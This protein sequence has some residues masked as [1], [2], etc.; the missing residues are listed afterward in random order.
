MKILALDTSSEY[1]SM[2][3][4]EDEKLLASQHIA[5]GRQLSSNLIKSVDSILKTAGWKLLDVDCFC[6]GLGPGS[7]TGLRIGITCMKGFALAL[8]K[9][10]KGISSLDVI[11]YEGRY[12]SG[13]ICPIIDAKKNMVYTAVYEAKDGSIVR[14]GSYNVLKIEGLLKKLKGE[15]LFLG[16]A[17][18]IYKDALQRNGLKPVFASQK[19]WYP[20]ADILTGL[21]MKDIL[22]RKFDDVHKLNPLY[23]HPKECTVTK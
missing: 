13:T 12:F 16:D 6:V 7:F 19:L 9:P 2:A 11:A 8:K 18:S 14:K 1:M 5:F 3:L 4:T 20:R 15:V 17:I 21:C 10:I 22:K 23:L